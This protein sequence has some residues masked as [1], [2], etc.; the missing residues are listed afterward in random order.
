MYI[1]CEYVANVYAIV[2]QIDESLLDTSPA[3]N[4]YA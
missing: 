3:L 2:I 1:H 4:D